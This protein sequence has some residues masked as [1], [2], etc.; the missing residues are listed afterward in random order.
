MSAQR[1]NF[2]G[3]LAVPTVLMA[4]A[5][6][7]WASLLDARMREENLIL[8]QPV[9]IFML[10]CYV[11]VLVFEVRRYRKLTAE[12]GAAAPREGIARELQF[13]ALAVVGAALFWAFG[14]IPAT[15]AVLAAGML[16][17]RVRGP[18]TLIVTS[19][20]TTLLLWAIFVQGFGI[21]MPLF[22]F[23]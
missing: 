19:A 1:W 20:V 17:L 15:L 21:R 22:R 11:S 7:Y 10:G 16:V 6:L 9:V 23:L 5:A 14:A 13:I 8:I 12:V 3:R 18:V 4:A 2:V